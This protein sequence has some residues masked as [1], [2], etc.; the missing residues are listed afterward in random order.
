MS[1]SVTPPRGD[2]VPGT[3]RSITVA[4]R[5]IASNS[6][7]PQYPLNVQTPIFDMIV[8]SPRS[9]ASRYRAIGRRQPLPSSDA[10]ASIVS[11]PSDGHTAD[12]PY[13]QSTAS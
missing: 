5:P 6:C 13:A 11:K 4:S 10:S 8:S 7:A 12:A 3:N 2:A 1:D 9:S